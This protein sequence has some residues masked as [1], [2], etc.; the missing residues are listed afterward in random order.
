LLKHLGQAEAWLDAVKQEAVETEQKNQIS[1]DQF[2]AKLE[3][4]QANQ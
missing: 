4:M 1:Q 2:E 3:A